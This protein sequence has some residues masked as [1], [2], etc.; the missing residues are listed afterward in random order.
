LPKCYLVR[1][2]DRA[3]EIFLQRL[4]DADGAQAVAADENSLR[5]L[6]RLC[7]DPFIELARLDGLSDGRPAGPV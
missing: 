4:D 6:G 3:I 1:S 5:V 7:T 2:Q